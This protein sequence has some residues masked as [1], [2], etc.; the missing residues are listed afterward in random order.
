MLSVRSPSSDI[1]IAPSSSSLNSDCDAKVGQAVLASKI[2]EELLQ[3][4]VVRRLCAVPG[5][6]SSKSEGNVKHRKSNVILRVFK[7]RVVE[8]A[9]NKAQENL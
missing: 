3:N 1:E 4:E 6:S 2:P 8:E 5:T 7:S 9:E